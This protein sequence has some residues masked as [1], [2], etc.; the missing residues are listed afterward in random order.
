MKITHFFASVLLL[1]L[2][3][4]ANA[5]ISAPTIDPSA[6]TTADFINLKISTAFCDAFATLSPTDRVLEVSP[7]LVKM[8]V[9]GLST[10]DFAQ[11]NYPRLNYVYEIG[12]LPSGT[13]RFELYR[14]I[15]L[16]PSR[17]NL[18]GTAN[19]I[20]STPLV[21]QVPSLSGLGIAGLCGVMLL[22]AF[23]TRRQFAN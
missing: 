10:D 13:Y 20:V 16:D 12:L 18:V 2:S 23:A 4:N 5:I 1:L 6:P 21:T 17:I 19:F 9:L 3:I 14:R 22:A 8:T 7:G 11:C 15:V